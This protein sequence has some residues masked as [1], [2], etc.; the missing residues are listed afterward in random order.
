MLF[1]GF[2]WIGVL[3]LGFCFPYEF[4]ESVM[5]VCCLFY[6]LAQLVCSQVMPSGVGGW[7]TGTS[8][9]REGG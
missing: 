7:D 3:F 2:C 5:V 4:S 1:S 8:G 9:G 6:W